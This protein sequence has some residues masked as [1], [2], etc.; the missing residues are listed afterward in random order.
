[1]KIQKQ[2]SFKQCPAHIHVHILTPSLR[3]MGQWRPGPHVTSVSKSAP[4]N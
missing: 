1:M 3:V 4:I 2:T